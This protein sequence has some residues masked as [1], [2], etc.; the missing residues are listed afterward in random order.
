MYFPLIEA[1][2]KINRNRNEGVQ[3]VF[4]LKTSIYLTRAKIYRLHT[5]GG[6]IRC[7]R[8]WFIVCLNV[9]NSAGCANQQSYRGIHKIK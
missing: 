3:R 9:T 8:K 7:S 1:F 4:T 6:S 5:E 2:N